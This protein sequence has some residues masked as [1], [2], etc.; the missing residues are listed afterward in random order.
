MGDHVKSR[1]SQPDASTQK[2]SLTRGF[3][4][5]ELLVVIA[6]ILIIAAIAI[7]NFMRS[8][9]RANEGAAAAN[10]RNIITSEVVYSTT[11]Q[12]GFS[13]SLAALGGSGA[14]VDQNN[15]E[16]IDSVLSSG[17]KSGYSYSYKVVLKDSAGHVQ[18]YSINADPLNV[19]QTGV[20]H[21]Y[22]DQTGVIR[23]NETGVAGPSDP[24]LQ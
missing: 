14:T 15:S 21:F 24:P 5:V 2:G 4:L 10:I 20:V 11:Y 22:A 13:P 12:I 23:R 18:E 8:R 19:G 3:S 7:P 16:L 17:A 1:R 6:V 9:M